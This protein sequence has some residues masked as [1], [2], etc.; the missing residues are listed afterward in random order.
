MTLKNPSCQAM[1]QEACRC[2]MISPIFRSRKRK[3]R[4][5]LTSGLAFFAEVCTRPTD[6]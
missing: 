6:K 3:D 5:N 2:H 1:A 4:G